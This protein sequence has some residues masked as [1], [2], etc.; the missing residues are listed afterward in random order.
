MKLMQVLV[1]SLFMCVACGAENRVGGSSGGSAADDSS[2]GG[3]GTDGGSGSSSGTGSDGGSDTGFG[4]GSFTGSDPNKPDAETV[5]QDDELD[6]ECGYGDVY[7]LICSMSE[8]MFVNGADVWIDT[9]DCNGTPVKR[10]TVS[11]ANG[12]YTLT[13]VP[14]G[15]QTVQIQK[16]IFTKQYNVVV[17]AGK[18]SDVTGVAHKECFQVV[19]SLCKEGLQTMNVE[20]EFVG[21][22]A[23]IVVFVDTSGSM[24]QESSWV[25]D[26]VNMF[27]QYIGGQQV[28]YHVVLVGNGF[29]LC[30]PPP[31]GGPNCTD[32]PKFRHVKE[33]IGSHNGLEKVISSYPQYQDFMRAGATTNFIAITD[34]NSKKSS[35]WFT[36]QVFAQQNPGFSNPFVFHSI[37]VYGDIPFVGCL[38][39]AYG[40]VVYLELTQQT[41]GSKFPVCETNWSSIFGQM[42]ETVVNTVQSTCAYQLKDPKAVAN[43]DKVELSYDKGAGSQT[44]Q[45]VSGPNQCGN[46]PSF[47]FDNPESPEKLVLCPTTCNL[48]DNGFLNLNLLCN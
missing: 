22:M 7:G 24:K 8:Q 5:S 44:F 31:L 45:L 29:D 11:D 13:Q 47:Y 32:G 2:F 23:D 20:S 37:V 6:S 30:V 3:F 35:S 40:G 27:A 21:A 12:F 48:L 43:A 16:D 34:D 19:G 26:N 17:K 33:K 28:D 1:F 38:G 41:G 9:L 15:I 36:N 25:Q 14:S 10:Q 18:L 4:S 39:G 42:A 46:G